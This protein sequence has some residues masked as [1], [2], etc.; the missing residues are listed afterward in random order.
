[1]VSVVFDKWVTALI[2]ATQHVLYSIRVSMLCC[3]L[4]FYHLSRLSIARP[5]WYSPDATPILHDI[6]QMPRCAT[7]PG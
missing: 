4:S 3:V 1:M 5:R 2:D 7:C 6:V